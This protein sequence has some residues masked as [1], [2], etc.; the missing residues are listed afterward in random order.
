MRPFVK[1][2]TFLL[3]LCLLVPA[4]G[5][6]SASAE[7]ARV[8]FSASVPDEEGLFDVS[9]TVYDPTFE[10]IKF[11]I[12][13]NADAVTPASWTSGAVT[14]NSTGYIKKGTAVDGMSVFGN[15]SGGNELIILGYSEN[16]PDFSVTAGTEG[17]ELL[18]VRFKVTVRE[19]PISVLK[20]RR[21]KAASLTI[22]SLC[23]RH[24]FSRSLR[25]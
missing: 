12:G 11:T 4:L 10:G 17:V 8:V 1:I 2:L 16:D 7:G 23:P 20:A 25:N 24:S 21:E 6:E 3:C 9:V 14:D 18:F 5:V 13:F 22:I 19:H 15:I